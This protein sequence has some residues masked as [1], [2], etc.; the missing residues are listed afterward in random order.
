MGEYLNTIPIERHIW[1]SALN[2]AQIS[3]VSSKLAPA[4]LTRQTSNASIRSA[5]PPSIATS[6][7]ESNVVR[8]LSTRIF[9]GR[10]ASV[11]I[12]VAES[13]Q[14]TASRETFVHR[15]SR[16]FT[17]QPQPDDATKWKPFAR[18]KGVQF[19]FKPSLIDA[20]TKPLCR[21]IKLRDTQSRTQHN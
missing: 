14:T 4:R 5:R 9:R 20:N 6:H 21:N 10:R 8:G 2:E 7:I 11:A 15:A 3:F 12:S 19:S 16:I 18:S 1:A 13:Q 17:R